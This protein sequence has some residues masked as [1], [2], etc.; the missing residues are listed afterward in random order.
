MLKFK[1]D[2]YASSIMIARAARTN[3]SIF[4]NDGKLDKDSVIVNYLDLCVRYD[5]YFSITKYTIQC[6][7]GN[8]NERLDAKLFYASS[9]TRQI[10]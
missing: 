2:S 10:W 4:K 8:I 5:N 9:D 3:C 7:L 1:Q 6:M